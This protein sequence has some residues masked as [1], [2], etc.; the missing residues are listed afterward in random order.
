MADDLSREEE[1]EEL[2]ES[3][4]TY[5]ASLAR[6]PVGRFAEADARNILNAVRSSK[7]H[8]ETRLLLPGLLTMVDIRTRE[9]VF[10]VSGKV[11]T[12]E[13]QLASRGAVAEGESVRFEGHISRRVKVR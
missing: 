12:G 5:V 13:N 6:L 2:V 10:Y 8:S 9:D 3:L 7:P 11:A 1:N 4:S